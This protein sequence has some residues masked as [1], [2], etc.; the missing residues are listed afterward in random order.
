MYNAAQQEELSIEYN[1]GADYHSELWASERDSMRNEGFYNELSELDCDLE[2]GTITKAC[3]TIRTRRI[4]DEMDRQESARN[5]ESDEQRQDRIIDAMFA[6]G[7]SRHHTLRNEDN[8][9]E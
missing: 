3:H 2:E 7:G 9:P 5:P 8:G 6:P 4:M 1:S